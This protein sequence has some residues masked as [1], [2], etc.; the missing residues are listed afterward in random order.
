MNTMEGTATTPWPSHRH[1][2]V[3]E[4]VR[5]AVPLFEGQGKC[6]DN[7]CHKEISEDLTQPTNELF[8][9]KFHIPVGKLLCSPDCDRFK[10]SGGEGL[11]P[12]VSG[13]LRHSPTGGDHERIRDWAREMRVA[14]S[15]MESHR[16]AQIVQAR[17][18]FEM[19]RQSMG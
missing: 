4:S 15:D 7:A 9:K 19:R 11:G 17:R 5:H 16:V 8:V 13:A 6:M 10:L 1:V 12:R 14:Q 18:F 2:C 3:V